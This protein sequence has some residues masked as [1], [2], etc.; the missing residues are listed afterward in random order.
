MKKI[1]ITGASTYGVKNM[2]DD[3]MLATLTQSIKRD[4]PDCEIIFI[5]RHPDLDYDEAF[6]FT[7]IKNLDH[8]T[9]EASLGRFFMGLNKGDDTTNLQRIKQEIEEADLL[10]LG[11]NSFM[12][13]SSN[14]FLRGV[15]SYSAT[16]GLLAKFLGTP[17]ALYGLNVV[18]PIEN[19]T[20]L[21]HAKFLCE[22]A[23]VVTVR[24]ESAFNYLKAT[25]ID[26]SN[27]VILG[28]PAFGIRP[29]FDADHARSVLARE[30]ITLPDG[31]IIGANYRHEYWV[32]SDEEFF[33]EAE[34]MANILDNLIE[35]L[36]HPVLLIPNCTYTHANKWQDDRIVHDEIIKRMKHTNMIQQIKQ[37]LSLFETY[38]LFQ[39]LDMHLSNRRHSS[40][41]AALN[42]VPFLSFG[43]IFKGHMSPFLHDLG[44]EGQ[45][46]YMSED[47]EIIR[48]KVLKTWNNRDN[49]KDTL[50][51]TIPE[52]QQ[53]A[54]SYL[55]HLADSLKND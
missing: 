22:N 36:G 42:K 10:V 20:T 40:I 54:R 46:A 45:M 48:Q 18:D 8:D 30:N 33:A 13:V 2:G 53:S 34:K 21:A 50:S 43:S 49:I 23:T 55:K 38:S 39:L 47:T 24:E 19:E 12:E 7:S 15:S 11:G 29:Q 17:F 3:A 9:R 31:P 51:K 41:F 25:G 1:V 16:L 26:M 44:L 6:G 27:V 37:D 28:D 52:L 35:D 5:A 14:E 32:R 4:Y